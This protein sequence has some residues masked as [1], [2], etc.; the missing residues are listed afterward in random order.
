MSQSAVVLV[1]DDSRSVRSWLRRH[2]GGQYTV[3]EAANGIEAIRQARLA[4]PD[5]VLLDVDMPEMD[6]HQALAALRAD[7]G[8]E[9]TP[10]L[11]LTGRTNT[12]DVVEGLAL[13]ASDYLRKPCDPDELL[14]RVR[15]ALRAKQRQDAL[16]V[17]NQK[18]AVATATDELTGLGNRR[19]ISQRLPV[20]FDEARRV[21]RPVALLLLDLDH[22]KAINDSVGHLAGDRV[23]VTV[24]HRLQAAVRQDQLVTRWGGEEFLIVSPATGEAEARVV[25]ERLRGVIGWEPIT[26]VQER[27]V[28]VTVSI[29][30]ATG[31]GDP[32]QLLHSADAALYAAKRHGRNCCVSA[33]DLQPSEQLQ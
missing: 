7:A 20:L 30:F 14:A 26:A 16:R 17:A 21:G 5:L 2:L 27:S 25:A 32:F 33:T 29:G 15:G 9:D 19:A 31:L 11:F 18:L 3:V 6:G 1:A 12:D 23:L 8:L 28:Q 24:A 4:R 10:V 22:F 13:G